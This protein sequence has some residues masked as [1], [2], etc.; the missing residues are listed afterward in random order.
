V[1]ARLNPDRYTVLA[2]ESDS[3]RP[4]YVAP[5]TVVDEDGCKLMHTST[6]RDPVEKSVAV[7]V[8]QISW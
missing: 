6:W 2:D 3:F 1:D 4:R 7:F 8:G 5:L